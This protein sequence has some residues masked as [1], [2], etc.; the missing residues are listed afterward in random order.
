MRANHYSIRVAAMRD[1]EAIDSDGARRPL[2]RGLLIAG[3]GFA[4]GLIVM[5]WL[6]INFGDSLGVLP[7]AGDT[8]ATRTEAATVIERG[9]A[10]PRPAPAIVP[11]EPEQF[12]G[13][14]AEIAEHIAAIEARL[15]RVETRSTSAVGNATRAEG[16]L[17]AFAARRA[18]DRGVALGYLETMLRERFGESEPRAVAVVISSA[19][20][21]VTL[22]GLQSRLNEISPTLVGRAPDE[23][24][25]TAMRREMSELFVLREA[26]TPSPAPS[27]R[28]QRARDKLAAGQVDSALAEVLRLPGQETATQWIADARRYVAARN[29]L[30]RIETVALIEPR[31]ARRREREAEVASE[32]REAESG[33]EASQ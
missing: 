2:P 6:L 30:D 3:L 27:D 17:V 10:R 22:D 19:R 13:E 33:A 32:E 25:W 26:G 5:A 16:L 15:A 11:I 4:G 20:Q 9:R 29:A 1:Y 8:P 28:L 23:G 12:S 14:E 24:W 21:P 18:L 7:A 31:M